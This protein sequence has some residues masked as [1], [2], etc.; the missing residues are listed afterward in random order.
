MAQS[1]KRMTQF[2]RT[3]LYFGTADLHEA[4]AALNAA[5][6]IVDDRDEPGTPP[7]RRK[8]RTK[9]ELAAAAVG[10]QANG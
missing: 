5:H 2:A 6:A 7:V 1:T 3:M 8:R 4:K 10:T 9:A